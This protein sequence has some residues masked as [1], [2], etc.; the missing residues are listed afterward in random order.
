MSVVI[1]RRA[2]PLVMFFF[3]VKSR[4]ILCLWWLGDGAYGGW[5]TDSKHVSSSRSRVLIQSVIWVAFLPRTAGTWTWLIC[6]TVF[7]VLCTRQCNPC[8]LLYTTVWRVIIVIVSVPCTMCKLQYMAETSQNLLLWSCWLGYWS[9]T[10]LCLNSL[11]YYP[12]QLLM[13]YSTFVWFH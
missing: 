2:L 8:S 6:A 10:Q 1:G 5:E 3:V 9:Y 4:F 13:H 7:L 11:T 12:T